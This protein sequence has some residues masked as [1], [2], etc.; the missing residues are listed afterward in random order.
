MGLLCSY[1]HHERV[2]DVCFSADGSQI[3]TGSWDCSAAI[4]ATAASAT[5]PRTQLQPPASVGEPRAPC[6][7]LRG[8]HT[9]W[10]QAVAASPCGSYICTGSADTT[11]VVWDAATG[12]ALH[13]LAGHTRA[14]HSV[15]FL[16]P[17]GAAGG[18]GDILTGSKE[19]NIKR[20]AG[21]GFECAQTLE[22]TLY[23]RDQF[24]VWKISVCGRLR[25]GGRHVAASGNTT[26]PVVWDLATGQ[27]LY[28]FPGHIKLVQAVAYNSGGS[29]VATASYDKTVRVFCT[30]V[31]GAWTVGNHRLLG[32]RCN[33]VL[34]TI[35]LCDR[36]LSAPPAAHEGA[37]RGN[38]LPTEVWLYIFS[39][40]Q[41]IDY[42]G[43]GA[44]V[45]GPAPSEKSRADRYS[46]YGNKGMCYEY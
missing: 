39:H 2:A 14:V 3:V 23:P 36:R 15:Q 27:I 1:Q 17:L 37:G 43:C 18:G 16:A 8:A 38:V 5:G 12:A 7:W 41:G 29:F 30:G 19:G 34:L 32:P 44:Q 24:S 20:W 6:V 11:A 33:E 9:D 40:L 26:T 4:H 31:F 22:Q 10:I 21:P 13:T 42:R 25:N 46:F 28:E 35:L 45:V